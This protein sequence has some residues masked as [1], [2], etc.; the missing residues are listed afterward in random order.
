MRKKCFTMF[1]S[2]LVI[3]EKIL[4]STVS[5]KK[6]HEHG[7]V[8]NRLEF[9]YLHLHQPSHFKMSPTLKPSESPKAVMLLQKKF[10]NKGLL[11]T[12]NRKDVRQSKPAYMVHEFDNSC[13]KFNRLKAGEL[14]MGV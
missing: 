5:I 6:H 4:L 9:R 13:T 3:G 14:N 8:K 2:F 1:A 7:M 10:C 11:P 12:D